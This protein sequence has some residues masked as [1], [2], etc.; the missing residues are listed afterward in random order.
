MSLQNVATAAKDLKT[1]WRRLVPRRDPHD[2][3]LTG[4]CEE[5]ERYHRGS[6]VTGERDRYNR[7]STV[8]V[9]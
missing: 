8:A 4:V 3:C 6:I 9:A 5:R 2:P 1:A 7:R